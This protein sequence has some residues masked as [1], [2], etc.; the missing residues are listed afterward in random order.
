MKDLL[1]CC[2]DEKLWEEIPQSQRDKIMDTYQ[3]LEQDLVKSGHYLAGAKLGPCST[4]ATVR[5][6]DG[7]PAITDGPF[8]ETK[9]QIGGYHLVECRNVDEAIALAMRIPTLP[10]GGSIEVRPVEQAIH[11]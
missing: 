1:M 4:A 5:S 3:A 6:H 10:V 11:I 9:E 8:A 7:K 2:I